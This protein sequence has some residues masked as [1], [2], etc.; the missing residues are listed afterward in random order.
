MTIVFLPNKN[1]GTFQKHR[2]KKKDLAEPDVIYCGSGPAQ[3]GFH[4]E[5]KRAEIP[6]SQVNTISWQLDAAI[7]V[8]PIR[9]VK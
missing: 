2:R 5:L 1:I 9:R 8:S 4:S 6:G 7:S 3:N